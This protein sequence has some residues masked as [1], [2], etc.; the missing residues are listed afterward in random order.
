MY[1]NMYQVMYVEKLY[2]LWCLQKLWNRYSFYEIVVRSAK[3]AALE[4]E[5]SVKYRTAK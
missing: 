1:P 4:N 2:P 5:R 3:L